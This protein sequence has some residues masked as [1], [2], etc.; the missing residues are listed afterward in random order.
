MNGVLISIFRVKRRTF[1]VKRVAIQA[2]IKAMKENGI[3]K[4]SFRLS[5]QPM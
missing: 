4:L 2:E 3:F 5:I 1:V